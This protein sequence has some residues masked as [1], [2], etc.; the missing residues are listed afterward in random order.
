VYQWA[1]ATVQ[2]AGIIS[3]SGFV[4]AQL[5]LHA[6]TPKIEAFY[7]QRGAVTGLPGSDECQS[8]VEWYGET[9]CDLDTLV[10]RV[11]HATID[12]EKSTAATR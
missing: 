8:W 12:A 11:G 1:L 5:A 6:A 9:I 3:E 10:H 2:E 7:Q 4:E